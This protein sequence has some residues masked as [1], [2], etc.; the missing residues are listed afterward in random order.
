MSRRGICPS[1][2]YPTDVVDNGRE[3]VA[4]ICHNPWHPHN[5]GLCP[6]RH[7]GKHQLAGMGMREAICAVPGCGEMWVPSVPR[8]QRS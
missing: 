7:A 8:Q 5:P 4:V 2:G 3:I 6:K 1:D